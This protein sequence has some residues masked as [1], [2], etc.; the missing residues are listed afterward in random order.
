MSASLFADFYIDY[1]LKSKPTPEKYYIYAED[2]K[3]SYLIEIYSSEKRDDVIVKLQKIISGN[4]HPKWA[5]KYTYSAYLGPVIDG[6]YKNYKAFDIP[7][8]Q[9]TITHGKYSWYNAIHLIFDV[10][11]KKM[12]Y[13]KNRINLHYID[14]PCGNVQINLSKEW[15]GKLSFRKKN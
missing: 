14:N 4:F 5:K 11:N 7:F 2:R 12:Y 3:G 15:N 10:N 8:V 13:D 6:V 1:D 9:F